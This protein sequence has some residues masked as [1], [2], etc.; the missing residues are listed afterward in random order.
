MTTLYY[1]RQHAK[2][3]RA[4]KWAGTPLPGKRRRR[5]YSMRDGGKEIDFRDLSLDFIR[6]QNKS[7]KIKRRKTLMIAVAKL[8][9][10]DG[11]L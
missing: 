6:N 7:K 3:R 10:E 2:P 11:F 1:F 9:M 4:P 8:M 5:I